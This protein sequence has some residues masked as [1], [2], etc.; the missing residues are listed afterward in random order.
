VS[1]GGLCVWG[2]QGSTWPEAERDHPDVVR[3][4]RSEF[5]FRLP[6]GGERCICALFCVCECVC[7]R[8]GAPVLLGDQFRVSH[9]SL[10]PSGVCAR[11]AIRTA[12]TAS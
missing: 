3:R 6:G 8:V 11:A 7:A 2:A 4:W 12:S 10:T 1:G 9:V 5:D